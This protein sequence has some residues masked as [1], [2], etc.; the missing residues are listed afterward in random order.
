LEGET[1]GERL[2]MI[3]HIPNHR[4]ENISDSVAWQIF[5]VD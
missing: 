5:Q 4:I 2:L 3:E 1:A